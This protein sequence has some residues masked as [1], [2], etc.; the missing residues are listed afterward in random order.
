LKTTVKKMSHPS[1]QQKA[2]IL[3]ELKNSMA[4][5]HRRR[6]GIKLAIAV[7]APICLIAI[8]LGLWRTFNN[9]TALPLNPRTKASFDFED[10]AESSKNSANRKKNKTIW[11]MNEILATT[12]TPSI[13]VE[14][15]GDEEMLELLASLG[16]PAILA[17]IDG[18]PMIFPVSDN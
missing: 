3:G 16:T 18:K 6:R 13:Q 8:S 9:P 4:R 15:I 5:L 7:I 10:R 2:R 17:Q 12:E 1:D 11:S 14:E